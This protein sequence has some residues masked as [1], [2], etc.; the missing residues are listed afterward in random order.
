[1][2][3]EIKINAK[4]F[5]ASIY[6]RADEDEEGT[7]GK[8]DVATKDGGEDEEDVTKGNEEVLSEVDE[9]LAYDEQKAP[10]DDEDEDEGDAYDY[11]DEEYE[12]EKR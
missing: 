3:I 5:K 6:L 9:E 2:K 8:E 11:G 1:M 12:D 10:A 7:E 4:I